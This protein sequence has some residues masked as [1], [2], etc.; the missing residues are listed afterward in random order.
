M[1]STRQ[2]DKLNVPAPGTLLVAE[3]M[4]AVVVSLSNVTVGQPDAWQ[5]INVFITTN[6]G[7]IYFKVSFCTVGWYDAMVKYTHYDAQWRVLCYPEH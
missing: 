1:S 6:D 4:T 2:T 7:E 3:D 5:G